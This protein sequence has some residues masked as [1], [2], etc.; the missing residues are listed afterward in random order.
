M[1][2]VISAARP[3]IAKLNVEAKLVVG[4]VKD[5]IMVERLTWR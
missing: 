1:G 4:M 5:R 3:A 2:I